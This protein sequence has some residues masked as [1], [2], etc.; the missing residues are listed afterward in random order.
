MGISPPA[1]PAKFQLKWFIFPITGAIIIGWLW[2][3]PGGLLGKA[4]AIAYAVCHR[5]TS[6]S[7]LIDGQQ[8]PLCARCTGM[9]LGA[10]LGL[11]FQAAQG[12]LGKM[13]S[14]KTYFLLGLLV[15]AFGI[16]GVN[17]YLHFFPQAPSLYQPQ[18]WLRLVTGTGM[19]LAM[20]AVLLPAFHQTMWKTW[21]S[22]SAVSSG[23]QL[24][25]LFALA[26]LLIVSVLSGVPFIALPLAVLGSVGVLTLLTMVYSMVLV[27]IF[28][29]D[30]TFEKFGQLWLPLMGGFTLALLQIG[31]TDLLRFA[32]TKTWSGFSL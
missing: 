22:R 25:V 30:N 27:M 16:D 6:H 1:E 29:K 8:F 17:S 2:L 4:D 24:A 15:A 14:L 26:G 19:G 3:T 32:L 10:L 13:P 28:K 18:N 20:V 11:A 5:I 7:F 31:V 12:R 9:Y 23:K 21:T